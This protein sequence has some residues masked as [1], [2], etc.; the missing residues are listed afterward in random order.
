VYW[1]VSPSLSSSLE[2][3]QATTPLTL[4]FQLCEKLGYVN[5]MVSKVSNEIDS[6]ER[7]YFL[8]L[9]R[10]TIHAITLN[11]TFVSRC[12][13]A[14]YLLGVYCYLL[15]SVILEFLFRRPLKPQP[16]LPCISICVRDLDIK[17]QLYS[18]VSNEIDLFEQT[19]LL[20]CGSKDLRYTP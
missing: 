10:F 11:L 17:I 7:V 20:F 5:T 14:P 15:C 2:G 16:F 3:L 4:H 8:W 18:K 19:C 13:S 6:F 9:E 12:N 1:Y